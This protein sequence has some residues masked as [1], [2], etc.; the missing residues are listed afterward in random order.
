MLSE[1]ERPI[2]TQ[3]LLSNIRQLALADQM[4]LNESKGWHVPAWHGS[5]AAV[6]SGGGTN[7]WPSNY[8]FR[9]SLNMQI[10]DPLRMPP[11]CAASSRW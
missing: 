4:Y 7:I 9:R 1:R 6:V 8:I 10:V 11:H 5:A 3:C 2:R